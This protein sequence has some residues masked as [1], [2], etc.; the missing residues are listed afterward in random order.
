V[1]NIIAQL[2][3]FLAR[4]CTYLYPLSEQFLVDILLK[5]NVERETCRRPFSCW[6][7]LIFFL[8]RERGTALANKIAHAA[9]S[10]QITSPMF[11]IHLHIDKS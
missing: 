2:Y 7:A 4:L 3:H 6:F 5:N 1:Q 8:Y 9:C 11:I 10:S